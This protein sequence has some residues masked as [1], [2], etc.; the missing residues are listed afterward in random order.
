[1]ARKKIEDKGYRYES[2]QE[3]DGGLR[4]LCIHTR[5]AELISQALNER[6][7]A[8]KSRAE[9][10]LRP[11]RAEMERIESGIKD[12]AQAHRED[13]G[14]LKSRKLN[15]GTVF[16]RKSTKLKVPAAREK[17]AKIIECLRKRGMTDCINTPEPKVNKEALKGYSPEIIAEIGAQ[18]EITDAFSYELD[19]TEV[20]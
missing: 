15:F 8:E 2:W 13:M 16:F 17:L 9:A 19:M 5:E 7:D 3:V 6:I 18:L 10:E 12:F 4:Q 20:K 14:G 11:I 1:M